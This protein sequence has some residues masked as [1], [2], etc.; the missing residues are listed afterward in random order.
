MGPGMR[1]SAAK[2]ED[3]APVPFRPP[4]ALQGG[5]RTAV[6]ASGVCHT[7]VIVPRFNEDPEGGDQ[8]ELS[9]ES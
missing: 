3:L 4:A 9:S 1:R 6:P 7:P 5:V 2:D 8:Y